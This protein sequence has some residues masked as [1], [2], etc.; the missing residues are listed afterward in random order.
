MKSRELKTLKG[1]EERL[2]YAS[3]SES[4]KLTKQLVKLKDDWLH[5]P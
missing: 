2:K 3:P 5:K 4:A 1:L